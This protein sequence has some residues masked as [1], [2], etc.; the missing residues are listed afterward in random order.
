MGTVRGNTVI[1]NSSA[2]QIHYDQALARIN[3]IPNGNSGE[4]IT[5]YSSV[6]YYYPEPGE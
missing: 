5:S 2:G 1:F 6:Y 3:D 4:A